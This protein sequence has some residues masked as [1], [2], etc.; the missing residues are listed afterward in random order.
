MDRVNS[1]GLMVRDISVNG[2][3]IELMDKGSLFTLMEMCMTD[4]GRTIRQMEQVF[5]CMLTGLSMKGYGEMTFNME[6]EWKHGQTA[7][8]TTVTMHSV[9]SMGSAHTNGTMNP[10]MPENGKKTRSRVSASTPGSMVVNMKVNGKPTTWK[11]VASTFG[12]MVANM[13]GNT[14]MTRS[15]ALASMPGQMA[16]ATKATGGKESNTASV[17]ISCQRRTRLSLACGRMARELNGLL[18]KTCKTSI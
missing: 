5:T 13:K 17:L 2:V 14:R 7:L 10:N 16:A 8:N 18:M 3:R 1:S 12:T 4:N 6:K 11:A 9:A 15:M